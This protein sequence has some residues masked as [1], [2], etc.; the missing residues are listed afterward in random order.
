MTLAGYGSN[1]V[2]LVRESSVALLC[3]GCTCLI[4]SF[5]L[6]SW[7]AAV[8]FAVFP[9]VL[10]FASAC[11][12][13]ALVVFLDAPLRTSGSGAATAATPRWP[14]PSSRSEF[15]ANL[16]ST[17]WRCQSS[18]LVVPRAA[19]L[20]TLSCI[21]SLPALSSLGCTGWRFVA[22]VLRHRLLAIGFPADDRECFADAQA[23]HGRTA[24]QIPRTEPGSPASWISLFSS[25]S[26]RDD[27]MVCCRIVRRMVVS[28]VFVRR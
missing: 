20:G 2:L 4:W 1:S 8:G 3:L 26:F 21:S 18:R 12:M 10:L 22:C 6:R 15:L 19:E 16:T 5:F 25:R 17:V 7:I 23:S 28:F 24:A 27:A 14:L 9:V 13:V 11:S